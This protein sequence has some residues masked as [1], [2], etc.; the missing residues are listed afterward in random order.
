MPLISS[1]FSALY[2]STS[3]ANDNSYEPAQSLKCR[4]KVKKKKK[5]D[6]LTFFLK[7]V[8]IAIYDLKFESKVNSS[9]QPPRLLRQNCMCA[10]WPYCP[11]HHHHNSYTCNLNT[12][13]AI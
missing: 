5:I 3:I 10:F 4:G 11:S 6:W 8:K 2:N 7:Q 13:A 9:M 1:S 12:L